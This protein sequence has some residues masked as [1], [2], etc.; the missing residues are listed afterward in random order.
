M[1]SVFMAFDIDGDLS[2]A[3]LCVKQLSRALRGP[4][5]MEKAQSA[6]LCLGVVQRDIEEWM[7]RNAE[8]QTSRSTQKR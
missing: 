1:Y 3:K 2:F 5:T 4:F 8:E 7:K 6:R